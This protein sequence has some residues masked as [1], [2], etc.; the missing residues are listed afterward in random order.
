MMATQARALDKPLTD[1]LERAG[2]RIDAE[3]ELGWQF[4]YMQCGGGYYFNVGCSEL[5]IERKVGLVRFADIEAFNAEGVKMR[6]G[7][8]IPADLVVLA[9]GYKG[10]EFLVRRLFGDTIADRVG[11]IWGFDEKKQELRNMWTPTGQ[12]GL[13]FIAGSFA[14]CRIYSKYLAL[15]IKAAE[16]G[17]TG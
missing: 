5:I 15:Q 6:G 10:L 4:K 12:R 13:W 1:K 8:V 11:P 2:F 9:T 14:Q 7:K 3:D 16:E 17:L